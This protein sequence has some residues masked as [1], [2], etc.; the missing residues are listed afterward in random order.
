MLLDVNT[1]TNLD[2]VAL[3]SVVF[4]FAL[5]GVF[6]LGAYVVYCDRLNRR[7]ELAA[8]DAEEH[9]VP[10]KEHPPSSET[11]ATAIAATPPTDRPVRPARRPRKQPADKRQ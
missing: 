10:A 11:T 1:T 3:L 4:F 2:A 6:A 8:M 9:A 7:N 5:L